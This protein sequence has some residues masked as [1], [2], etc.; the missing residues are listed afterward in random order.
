MPEI[1]RTGSFPFLFFFLSLPLLAARAVVRRIEKSREG[2]RAFFPVFPL[3]FGDRL[4]VEAVRRRGRKERERHGEFYLSGDETGDGKE[5]KKCGFFFPS[6]PSFS[7]SPLLRQDK[8]ATIS[9]EGEVRFPPPLAWHDPEV[10]PNL[11]EN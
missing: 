2:G 5:K 9:T 7:P 10:I 8:R 11:G 1:M 6:F 4:Y 3:P